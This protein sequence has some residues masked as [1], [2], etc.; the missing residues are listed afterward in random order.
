MIIKKWEF[1]LIAG[2]IISILLSTLS[3]SFSYNGIRE[4]VFRIHI[5]A[6][7]D[8][9]YDQKIKLAVRDELQ[10]CAIEMFSNCESTEQAIETGKQNCDIFC[11]IANKKLEQLNCNYSASVCVDKEY[12]NTRQYE[13]FTLP[14]G[15]YDALVV[16]LGEAEGKNWWCCLYPTVCVNASSENQQAENVMNDEQLDIIENEP[17]YHFR[18]K[19]VELIESIINWF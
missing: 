14:A 1:S 19:L 15:N 7:S 16:S 13:S 8:S 9:D 2:L 11:D 6:N 4:N 17:K 18:F 5:L 12:F 3:F 10:L